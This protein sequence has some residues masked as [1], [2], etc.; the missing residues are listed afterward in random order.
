MKKWVK[1]SI[2]TVSIILI[3]CA[4]VFTVFINSFMGTNNVKFDKEKL[5]AT[6][7]EIVVLDKENNVIENNISSKNLVKVEELNN[8]TINA[9]LSIEGKSFF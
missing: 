8:H 6:N 1:I 7:Q 4:L 2:I 3:I 9:F 5:I